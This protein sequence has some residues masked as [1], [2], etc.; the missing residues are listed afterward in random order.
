[1]GCSEHSDVCTHACAHTHTL[2]LSLSLSVTLQQKQAYLRLAHTEA[3][4]F[5]EQIHKSNT[6]MTAAHY[7]LINELAAIAVTLTDQLVHLMMAN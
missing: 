5:N 2:S 3:R 1:M 7:Q 4:K 6:C